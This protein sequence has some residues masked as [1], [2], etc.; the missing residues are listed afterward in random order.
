MQ[1]LPVERLYSL[2]VC[3]PFYLA[4]STEMF[5]LQLALTFTPNLVE[6][7]FR[8]PSQAPWNPTTTHNHNLRSG[9]F[10]S[11]LTGPAT[12]QV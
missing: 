8:N 6:L 11:V 7:H 2:D 1:S 10:C 3:C 12:P 4:Y 5:K 9:L